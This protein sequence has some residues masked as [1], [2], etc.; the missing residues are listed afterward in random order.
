MPPTLEFVQLEVQHLVLGTALPA[1]HCSPVSRIPFPHTGLAAPL[2][3]IGGGGR[4][5]V[6]D[7]DCGGRVFEGVLD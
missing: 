3:P 6:F 4:I 7:A 2:F 1:S 5:A